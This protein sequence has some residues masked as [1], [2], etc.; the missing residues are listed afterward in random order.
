MKE[1]SVG[2]L[3]VR[4]VMRFL[5]SVSPGIYE[6]SRARSWGADNTLLCCP[7]GGL[8]SGHAPG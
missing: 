6:G 3:I 8:C 7:R 2:K 5:V 4:L 1:I